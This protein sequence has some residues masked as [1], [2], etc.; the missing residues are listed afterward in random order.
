MTNLGGLG[1]VS[2][3]GGADPG[4][5]RRRVRL[6]HVGSES[7]PQVGLQNVMKALA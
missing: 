7:Q 6:V 1:L 4:I 5:R 2:L 3:V